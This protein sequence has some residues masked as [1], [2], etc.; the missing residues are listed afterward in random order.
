MLTYDGCD[1]ERRT[2]VERYVGFLK[3]LLNYSCLP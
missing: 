2:I 1:A 3:L